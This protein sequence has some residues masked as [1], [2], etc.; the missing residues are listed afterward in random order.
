MKDNSQKTGTDKV[1]VFMNSALFRKESA[2]IFNDLKKA[3]QC[4]LK[5]VEE[6]ETR[7]HWTVADVYFF[8]YFEKVNFDYICRRMEDLAINARKAMG[9]YTEDELGSVVE[10]VQQDIQEAF[11]E[12]QNDLDVYSIRDCLNNLE[13]AIYSARSSLH[14]DDLENF[15]EYFD[16][17]DN[18]E[19][20]VTNGE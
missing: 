7:E 6:V 18:H 3:G 14:L 4:C 9:Q 8:F 12:I 2:E 19:E 16:D 1:A 13:A 5:Y 20:A 11:S 15:E 10:D 17:E